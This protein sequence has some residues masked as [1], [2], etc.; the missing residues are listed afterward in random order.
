[1]FGTLVGEAR[2]PHWFVE[3]A[4]ADT[5]DG[6]FAVLA[7]VVALATVRLEAGGDVARSASVGLAERFV[8][9]MDSEHRELGL[10]DPTLGRTVRKLVAGL[11]RRVD[12]WRAAVENGD[13]WDDAAGQS[14]FG[15]VAPSEQAL[16]HVSAALRALWSRLDAAP[17]EAVAVGRFE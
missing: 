5:I 17:D 4:V 3:G 2:Q 14:L 13:S 11:S 9:A 10:G 8:E 16:L 15:Q 1:L 6:R 7:T 12:L